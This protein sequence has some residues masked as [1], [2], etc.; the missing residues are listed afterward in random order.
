MI[1]ESAF[2]VVPSEVVL[3]FA[4]YLVFLGK[5]DFWLAVIVASIGSLIGTLID[6]YIG[7]FLGR[8]AI[9]KYGRYFRLNEKH[10]ATSEKWFT[11][12]GEMTVLLARFVPA[13]R[14]LVGFPAGIGEMKL[15]RFVAFSTV[16]IVV[17]DA[18]LIYLGFIAGLNSSAIINSLS[19]AFPPIEVVAVVV[20]AIALILWMRR[21]RT[22]TAPGTTPRA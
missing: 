16:G 22:R 6:Y 17:W 5:I 21:R 4:G 12:Y 3:P 8:E 1:A 18:I 9:L 19:R 15:W 11:K 14:A 10:L 20:A 7:Y 2:P 13:I